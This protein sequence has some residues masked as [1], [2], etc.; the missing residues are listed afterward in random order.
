MCCQEV[1]S[2]GLDFV[3]I[4]TEHVPLDRGQL[5]QMCLTYSAMGIPSLVRIPKADA[6][7]ARAVIDAGACGVVSSYCETV[8][9]VIPIHGQTRAD[10]AA[11]RQ[12]GIGRRAPRYTPRHAHV[13]PRQT[14]RLT[15][16]RHMPRH[17]TP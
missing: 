17:I 12:W 4:D 14:P 16:R 7:M 8:E 2:C 6:V 5:S 15:P 3:F 11:R 13:T 10:G 1:A 9:Q